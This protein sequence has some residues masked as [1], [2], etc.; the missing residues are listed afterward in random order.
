MRTLVISG[1]SGSGKSSV[2]KTLEDEG[3]YCVDNLPVP[4]LQLLF[5]LI[6]QLADEI[7]KLAL[8]IDARDKNHI[9]QLPQTLTSLSKEGREIELIFLEASDEVLARRFNE[10][11]HR[12]HLSP[13][14]SVLE[15]IQEER[16]LLEPVRKMANIILDTSELTTHD[17]RLQVSKT[18]G[19]SI[20]KGRLA[21]LVTSFG[22]KKGIPRNAD[23]VFDVRFLS[24]PYFK[25]SLKEKSGLDKGVI[26]YVLNQSDARELLE[27]LRRLFTFLL[28]RYERE[29]KSYL[30]VAMGCTG[31]QHRSVVLAMELTKILESL[32]HSVNV[33]HRDMV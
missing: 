22:F 8:V 7:N 20:E 11:R 25:E 32:G 26:K 6:S 30:H 24:N 29:S 3:F 19:A 21:I 31:G 4:L 1:L 14:G 2:V 28:P 13:D 10:T 16:K 17:L 23:L 15:G 12:H 33:T 27:E 5:S 18:F 9:G